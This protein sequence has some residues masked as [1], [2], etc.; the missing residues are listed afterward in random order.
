MGEPQPRM[1]SIAVPWRGIHSLSKFGSSA[2]G[3]DPEVAGGVEEAA[4]A[5]GLLSLEVEAGLF[6]FAAL[7]ESD[8]ESDLE[9][10]FDSD[11]ESAL[12]SD[13]PP[14]ELPVEA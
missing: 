14:D 11:L 8:F 10:D 3:Y 13:S 5:L 7:P 12:D 9:S 1:V 4:G 6:S 2:Q